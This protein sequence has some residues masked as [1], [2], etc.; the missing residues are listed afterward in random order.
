MLLDELVID[1]P[2][3]LLDVD[4]RRPRCFRRSRAEPPA[5]L[6]LQSGHCLTFAV[7]V[8]RQARMQ[9]GTGSES[10]AAAPGGCELD[11]A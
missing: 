1:G 7:G 8:F 2:P 6:P 3:V 4:S 10:E 11:V 9:G 5:L